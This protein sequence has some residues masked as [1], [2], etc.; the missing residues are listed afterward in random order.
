MAG[1]RIQTFEAFWPY[2]LGEH[3]NP[4]CRHLHFVGTTLAVVQVVL[5]I[6]TLTP[7]FVLGALISGY[8]WAWIGH[9]FVEKNRPAT[10]TYPLWSLAADFKMWA[11][12]LRGKL[13]SGE[14]AAS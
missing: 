10:F 12:M 5:A 7:L 6:V 9:F 14:P 13:W 2:Y 8:F 1:E 11:W 3:R 4:T